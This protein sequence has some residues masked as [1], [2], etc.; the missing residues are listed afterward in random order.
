MCLWSL[1]VPFSPFSLKPALARPAARVWHLH[2]EDE[3]R[4]SRPA[5]RRCC[6]RHLNGSLEP[7]DQRPQTTGSEGRQDVWG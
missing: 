2:T 4:A 6:N 1:H 5:I 7:R 3:L